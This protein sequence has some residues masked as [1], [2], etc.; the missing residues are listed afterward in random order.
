MEHF[1]LLVGSLPSGKTQ[2]E[3]RE[4]LQRE[5][6]MLALVLK[7]GRNGEH[8]CLAECDTKAAYDNLLARD[9]ITWDDCTLSIRTPIPDDTSSRSVN[10]RAVPLD[11]SEDALKN[12]MEQ[13]GTVETLHIVRKVEHALGFVTFADTAGRKRALAQSGKLFLADVRLDFRGIASKDPLPKWS[14]TILKAEIDSL[15]FRVR[16]ELNYKAL[17]QTLKIAQRVRQGLFGSGQIGLVGS[18][19]LEKQLQDCWT[20]KNSRLTRACEEFENDFASVEQELPTL[21]SATLGEGFSDMGKAIVD[22]GTYLESLGLPTDREIIFKRRLEHVSRDFKV[23]WFGKINGLFQELSEDFAQFGE[24]PP[25]TDREELYRRYRSL[26]DLKQA[27]ADFVGLLHTPPLRQFR[28][29]PEVIALERE[30]RRLWALVSED[31]SKTFQV[32]KSV[33]EQTVRS[34]YN[35]CVETLNDRSSSLRDKYDELEELHSLL[36]VTG[37][38]LSDEELSFLSHH[39]MDLGKAI[40]EEKRALMNR[41]RELAEE[42]ESH[43]DPEGLLETV[44]ALQQQKKV[45]PLDGST[46][47]HITDELNRVWE[48]VNQQ[49]AESHRLASEQLSNEIAEIK[50][51][52]DT[53]HGGELMSRLKSVNARV[54]RSRLSYRWKAV[55]ENQIGTLYDELTRRQNRDQLQATQLVQQVEQSQET[56]AEV[57]SIIAEVKDCRSK[58]DILLLHPS[59]RVELRERLDRVS[60]FCGAAQDEAAAK[61]APQVA[62]CEKLAN[63][64]RFDA[65]FSEINRIQ[66]EISKLGPS[67]QLW[68][69]RSRLNTAWQSAQEKQKESAGLLQSLIED[70]ISACEQLANSEPDFKEVAEALSEASRRFRDRPPGLRMEHPSRYYEQRIQDARETLRRREREV[71]DQTSSLIRERETTIRRLMNEGTPTF[72][73]FEELHALTDLKRFHWK[74]RDEMDT[75]DQIVAT[76]WEDARQ[77]ASHRRTESLNAASEALQDSTSLAARWFDWNYIQEEIERTRSIIRGLPLS[78]ETRVKFLDHLDQ[79]ENHARIRQQADNS[80]QFSIDWLEYRR[81]YCIARGMVDIKNPRWPASEASLGQLS[82]RELFVLTHILD[83]AP[84]YSTDR[85][86]NAYCGVEYD[87]SSLDYVVIK[88]FPLP[89]I[90]YQPFTRIRIDFPRAYPTTPPIGWYMDS[91][92]NLRGW[93][94]ANHYFPDRAFHGA[95]AHPGLAWYCC[96]VHPATE[97]GGWRPGSWNNPRHRDNLWSF[98]DVVTTALSSDE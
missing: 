18:L 30:E 73:I 65:V 93:R 62:S 9:G 64:G 44:K 78:R 98:F 55:L 27:L 10:V 7:E 24:H 31:F 16:S 22:L 87:E 84:R 39:R 72:R 88:K 57:S 12:V 91:K 15:S 53:E 50:G 11:C 46:F 77:Y 89:T 67:R 96:T 85:D 70:R 61:L 38:G 80:E 26:R 36:R 51:L 13:F 54:K 74:N 8:Y 66:Q 19:E 29:D 68:M 83:T 97:R 58:L 2:D 20:L 4:F 25:G 60:Q 95:E 75:L 94:M 86:G 32:L 49:I 76:I 47:R 14:V 56:S 34:T 23:L 92:L 5:G 17:E 63:E 35:D 81:S 3:V 28:D 69:L 43:P 71:G 59:F 1:N 42:A 79:Q 37:V 41:V 6:G 82:E 48:I 52:V 40:D 33:S 21:A 45:I 90:W